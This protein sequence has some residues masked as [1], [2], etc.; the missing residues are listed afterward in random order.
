[1]AP[2]AHGV[3]TVYTRVLVWLGYPFAA[4]NTEESTPC[5]R[6][7]VV[8]RLLVCVIILLNHLCRVYMFM[9]VSLLCLCDV[10]RL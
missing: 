2:A 4:C 10:C 5:M 8:F 7:I 6:P 3:C 1:M 9:F